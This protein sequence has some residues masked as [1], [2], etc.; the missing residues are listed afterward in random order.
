[1]SPT[2]ERPSG[3]RRQAVDL[4]DAYA[5][6]VI[7]VRW[8]D[9]STYTVERADLG[10][11]D[12][13]FP[14]GCDAVDVITAYNPGSRQLPDEVNARRNAALAADLRAVGLDIVLAVGR[15][16]DGND[17]W[18]EASFAVIDADLDTVLRLGRAHGQRAIYR[19]TREARTVITCH[20]GDPGQEHPGSR[21]GWRSRRVTDGAAPGPG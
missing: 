1:L 5:S 7:E 15:A 3:D 9:G 10:V 19:W 4:W 21:H 6:S 18:R 2:S 20:P 12:G 13:P 11:T 16:P 8:R 17:P 14:P